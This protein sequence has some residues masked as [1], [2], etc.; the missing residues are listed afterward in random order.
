MAR[1]GCGEGC[2]CLVQADPETPNLTVTGTGSPANPYVISALGGGVDE[3]IID[4]GDQVYVGYSKAFRASNP[5]NLNHVTGLLFAVSTTDIVF[6][7][8]RNGIAIQ[9]FTIPALAQFVE[10][11]VDYDYAEGDLYQA[12]VSSAGSGG[13]GLT[14][15]GAFS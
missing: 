15:Q 14:V 11:D 8:L 4:F 6:D 9:T 1:C 2:S 12:Y 7:I 13:L 5:L 3:V 10:V